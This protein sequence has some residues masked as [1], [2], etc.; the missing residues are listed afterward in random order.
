MCVPR[1]VQ[2]GWATIVTRGVALP[3]P[4]GRNDRA[5]LKMLSKTAGFGN[6]RA[7]A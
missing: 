2:T 6:L 1:V 3:V 4:V 5:R 7:F